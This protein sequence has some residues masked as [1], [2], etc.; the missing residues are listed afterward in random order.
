[1][2]KQ[3]KLM[4]RFWRLTPN[5]LDRC[6]EKKFVIRLMLNLTFVGTLYLPYPP[7]QNAADQG[8]QLS[9][10]GTVYM[11]IVLVY[12]VTMN[13][14]KLTW[15]AYSW[16]SAIGYLCHMKLEMR[17]GIFSKKGE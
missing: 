2:Y 8:P 14:Q 7:A 12:S 5:T 17:E 16:I 13:I 1:M 10:S 3:S 15:Q 11:G 6:L 9:G 4:D